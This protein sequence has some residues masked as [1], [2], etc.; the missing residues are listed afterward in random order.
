MKKFNHEKIIQNITNLLKNG[1]Q[2]NYIKKQLKTDDPLEYYELILELSTM[3]KHESKELLQF[4]FDV[5]KT[6]YVLSVYVI[7]ELAEDAIHEI[8]NNLVLMIK[9][10]SYTQDFGRY[11]RVLF[12]LT[13]L[14]CDLLL[15]HAEWIHPHVVM[16]RAMSR[17]GGGGV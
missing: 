10:T 5:S 12:K 11:S 13:D 2:I 9:D 6:D 8:T 14:H 17:R 7:V 16:K 1:C 4:E 15:S 3:K